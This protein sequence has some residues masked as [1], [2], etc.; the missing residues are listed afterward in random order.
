MYRVELIKKHSRNIKRY[1]IICLTLLCIVFLG[2]FFFI[3]F[4]NKNK[5]IKL[6]FQE[7]QEAELL[8]RTINPSLKWSGAKGDTYNISAKYAIQKDKERIYLASLLAKVINKSGKTIEAISNYAEFNDSVKRLSL[9]E[10]IKF[11]YLDYNAKTMALDIDFKKNVICGREII[12]IIGKNFSIK[13]NNFD[14]FH[15]DGKM[16]LT[17]NVKFNYHPFK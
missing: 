11:T 3:K 12:N 7:T 5:N 17:G 16:N 6:S 2:S 15:E 4:D 10:D 14:F 9:K 1:K 8:S 13:A